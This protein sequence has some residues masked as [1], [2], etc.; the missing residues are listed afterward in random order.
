MERKLDSLKHILK[1]IDEINETGKNPY[2]RIQMER[3]KQN[4]TYE[5]LAEEVEDIKDN[6]D[7][8][9]IKDTELDNLRKI[10]TNGKRI[11]PKLVEILNDIL[12]IQDELDNGGVVAVYHY[13]KNRPVHVGKPSKD[14]KEKQQKLY[15]EAQKEKSNPEKGVYN[16]DELL[17]NFVDNSDEWD[18]YE[19]EMIQKKY[20]EEVEFLKKA[21]LIYREIPQLF[22]EI[23]SV[24]SF[25]EEDEE[26]LKALQI[27]IRE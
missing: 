12:G 13:E 16:I 5:R 19:R 24:I 1:R 11:K 2:I 20:L 23:F 26:K 9:D 22:D 18:Y 14:K 10:L 8:K 27:E 3:E 4:I 6:N 25:E 17:L 7:I 21:L 15:D